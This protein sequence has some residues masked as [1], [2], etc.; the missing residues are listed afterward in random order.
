MKNILI[1]LFCYLLALI[2]MMLTKNLILGS[3][4]GTGIA[5]IY[6]IISDQKDKHKEN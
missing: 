4:I 6:F 3:L 1:L 5:M 2:I